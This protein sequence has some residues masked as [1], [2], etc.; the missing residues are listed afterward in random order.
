MSFCDILFAVAVSAVVASQISLFIIAAS[1]PK[2]SSGAGKIAV[3]FLTTKRIA[4]GNNN[5]G[6]VL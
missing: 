1:D 6:P 2:F 4:P 3:N 5:L